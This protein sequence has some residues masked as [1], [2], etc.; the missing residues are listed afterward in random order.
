ML[1]RRPSTR[2]TTLPFATAATAMT[3][4][5]LITRSAIRIVLMACIKC[6]LEATSSSSPSSGTSSFT[7]IQKSSAPPMSLSQGSLS[8]STATMVRTMRSTTAAAAPQKIA[9]FCCLAGSERAASAITTALSPD[10]M[11][12]TQMIAPSPSQNC[13]VN[14][15]C[16]SVGSAPPEAYPK[17]E[18]ADDFAVHQIDL[19]RRR[20]LR[21]PRHRHDVA[22]DHHHELGARREPYLPDVDDVGTR[23]RAQLRIGGKGILRLRHAH[24]IVAVA[25]VLQALDLAAYLCVRR[26]LGGAVHLFRDLRDLLPQRVGVLVDEGRL[27][28]LL[29]QLDHHAREL[30]RAFA[31]VGPVGGEDHG[32]AEVL[33]LLVHQIHLRLRVVGEAVERH[34]A[35][36]AVDLRHVLD[37]ALEVHQPLLQRGEVL[38]VDL[39]DL[40]AAVVLERAQ[41]RHDHR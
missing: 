31:A 15:S 11:I 35:G 4:S 37:V 41:R 28:R 19:V 34:D 7:A 39:L 9:C 29:A 23:R 1:I 30:R 20:H 26:D 33:H 25:L 22:A 10:R 17:S 3:L 40:D 16:I 38:L 18:Q 8:S 2:S 24:R 21:Q 13:E 12:L 6:E 27:R 32:H 5:R 14:S 36:N